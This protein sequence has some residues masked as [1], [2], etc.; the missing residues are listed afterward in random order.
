MCGIAGFF[1]ARKNLSDSNR[2]SNI[3]L[4]L[5]EIRVRGPDS[6]GIW[7][8]E[9]SKL[10]LGHQ[11]L[12]IQDLTAAGAQPMISNCGQYV[13]VFNGEIYNH[14]ELRSSLGNK[15]TWR[16]SSDTETLL[17][18][19]E[20]KG[21]EATL[22]LLNGMFAFAVWN[23]KS[24]ELS[25]CRD[26]FGEK[27]IYYGKQGT[28]SNALFVFGSELSVLKANFQFYP[29][30]CH[31]AVDEM[32]RYGCVGGELS[33]YKNVKKVLPGHFVTFNLLS[34]SMT[35]KE[36][37]SIDSKVQEGKAN[38]FMGDE[39]AALNKTESLLSQAIS[40]QLISDV[41]VGAFLSG[42]IDS[43]V[44]VAL[45]QEQ[46]A[47]QVKTFSIGFNESGYNEAPYAAAVAS[48]L[49]TDHHELYVDAQ[50]AINV[51]PS[52]PEIYSE[53]FGDSSQIPTFLVSQMAK[54]SVT[55]S[56]SGD[57]GDE[58]FGGYSRYI[59]TEKLWKMLKAMPY[60]ARCALARLLLTVNSRF[61][62][63]ISSLNHNPNIQKFVKG[64]RLLASKS[65]NE[66]YQNMLCV[67]QGGPITKNLDQNSPSLKGFVASH[68]SPFLS[69][70]EQMMLA[71]L[72]QYL[73]DDILVKVDRAAMACSLETRVPML[74][75]DLVE[76][77]WRLPQS[78]KIR[79]GKTKWPLRQILYR[80][81]PKELIERPKV[82]F[83]VPIGEWMKF[84]LREWCEDLLSERSLNAHD[85]ICTHT[86]RD[87]WK[88][89]LSGSQNW[90][91][92]L[93]NVLMFQAW[94]RHYHE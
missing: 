24:S 61:L 36:W 23:K 27:P 20:I 63:K 68:L 32:M 2:L 82:G 35:V 54:Q 5:N 26:R 51:I 74:D 42:G 15:I 72:K 12:A 64:L 29:E 65:S 11:R 58:V 8:C 17:R 41:P 21:L 93:W 31:S 88:Q 44:V 22:P 71:D 47:G 28:G 48:H 94:Y 6:N 40:R 89:H 39:W 56:L 50:T 9:D 62:S 81:V 46:F 84:E 1:D 25:L 86:I 19:I 33:I 30:I 57:A 78:Y 70:V 55:V 45:M 16:G 38:T 34:N 4:M 73:A 14:L 18:L 90:Q 52:M 87:L 13:V 67:W 69:D 43:S 66:L 10:V 7:L 92:R 60:P 75:H 80:H 53:P 59:H 83:G 91:Y 3:E 76:F 79:G 37:Y 77:A 85:F 49:G